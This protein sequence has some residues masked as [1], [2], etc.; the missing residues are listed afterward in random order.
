VLKLDETCKIISK[1]R[2]VT[3]FETLTNELQS[4]YGTGTV[5][6]SLTL[7]VDL[8]LAQVRQLSSWNYAEYKTA[9]LFYKTIDVVYIT[10][11][12][13]EESEESAWKHLESVERVLGRC[14]VSSGGSIHAGGCIRTPGACEATLGQFIS[15]PPP[16]WFIIILAIVAFFT[17]GYLAHRLGFGD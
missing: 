2:T 9:R 11:A 3:I 10:L 1:I 16:L 15:C 17:M 6:V 7:P 4:L 8:Y 12:N 14:W 5:F 13:H